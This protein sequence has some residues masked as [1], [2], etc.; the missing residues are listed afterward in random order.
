MCKISL[1]VETRVR[2]PFWKSCNIRS[3]CMICGAMSMSNSASQFG[4]RC[5]AARRD[6]GEGGGMGEA[7]SGGGGKE[8]GGGGTIRPTLEGRWLDC[9]P[10]NTD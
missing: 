4:S 8:E 6:W 3:E 7:G 2:P 9:S 5:S 1:E 10:I